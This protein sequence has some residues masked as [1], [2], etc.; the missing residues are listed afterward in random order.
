MLTL[1]VPPDVQV[2]LAL[3]AAE[4]GIDLLLEKPLA[5]D[6]AQARQ[7]AD[8]VGDVQNRVFPVRTPCRSSSACSARCSRS[9]LP[10]AV[11]TSCMSS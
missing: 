8:A 11:L 2:G 10:P 6:V 7:L 3:Q 1:A 5:L 4:R 9:E